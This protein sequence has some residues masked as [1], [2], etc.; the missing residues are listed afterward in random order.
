MTEDEVSTRIDEEV[1]ARIKALYPDLSRYALSKLRDN[2]N[3]ADALQEAQLA[4]WI[5]RKQFRSPEKFT[6]WAFAILRN[7]INDH[8]RKHQ[9]R[10][11][12]FIE[13]ILETIGDAS[14]DPEQRLIELERLRLLD[15]EISSLE[16][17]EREIVLLRHA[18]LSF[19]Q[20]ADQVKKPLGS[21][22]STYTRAKKK[23]RK[24]IEDREEPNSYAGN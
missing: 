3:A 13:T 12:F 21:V 4:I 24:F 18:N 14:P 23:I 6:G 20:I 17:N 8:F 7:K 2:Q 10:R 15:Q 16:D 5:A 11:E 19:A 22:S 9:T 1:S